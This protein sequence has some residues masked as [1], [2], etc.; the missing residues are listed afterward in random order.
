MNATPTS[1]PRPSRSR[2]LLARTVAAAAL[3]GLTAT[4]VAPAANAAGLQPNPNITVPMTPISIPKFTPAPTKKALLVLLENGGFTNGLPKNATI[5][6]PACSTFRL[7]AGQD[8]AAYIGSIAGSLGSALQCLNPAN[9]TTVQIPVTKWVAAVTDRV[10][11]DVTTTAIMNSGVNNKYDKVVILQDGNFNTTRIRQELTAMAPTYKVDVHVLAHGA[12]DAINGSVTADDIRNFG[13]IP[14]LNLRTVYQM[15]CFGSFLNSAWLDAGAR[16]VNGSSMLNYMSLDYSSF[17]AR[18]L[19][20]HSFSQAVNG[21]TAE[22]TPFYTS[23]FHFADLFIEN[24]GQRTSRVP[25]QFDLFG[26]LSSAD[27]MSDSAMVIQ[28]PATGTTI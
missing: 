22:W 9:W 6:V 16:A 11:E 17:L 3:V 2:R 12:T 27:E 8:L 24:G 21:S 5:G 10:I 18:W 14:G 28:G 26:G 1:R 25:T 15:N 19:N 13:N 4:A 23:V 20:G 7:P